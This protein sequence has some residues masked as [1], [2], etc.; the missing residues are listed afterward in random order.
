MNIIFKQNNIIFIIAVIFLASCSSATLIKTSDK[1]V[2]IYVDGKFGGKGEYT[3][4]DSK[5][6]GSS[7]HVLLTKVG[8]ENVSY[9]IKRNEKF[10]VG[11]CTGGVFL[12]VPLLWIKKYDPVHDFTFVCV[13]SNQNPIKLK[14][15]KANS[16][17]II[18]K[19][20]SN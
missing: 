20:I 14:N 19:K 18:I 4:A 1:D 8:C 7:T 6:A 15:S 2:S 12:L 5:I 10:D 13:D 17:K 16:K 11:A 9:V 3:Y